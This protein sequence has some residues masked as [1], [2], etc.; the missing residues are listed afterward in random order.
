[1]AWISSDWKFFDQ[2]IPTAEKWRAFGE[3]GSRALYVDI[4]TDGGMDED[5]ITVLGCYDGRTA[6]TF[7]RGRDLESTV[8]DAQR[9]IEEQVKL[10]EGF[11]TEWHGEYDQLQD[12]KQRL[13]KIVPVTLLLIFLLVYF[14]LHSLRDAV[15]VLIA[16]PFSLR[17]AGIAVEQHWKIYLPVMLASFVLML[18]AVMGAHA[19]AKLKGWF[20]AAVA[21]LLLVQVLMP[22]L[23]GGVWSITLFLLLFFKLVHIYKRIRY[24][25]LSI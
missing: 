22:W 24:R 16:V 2:R 3:L 5:C 4:E 17:N 11:R 7:V 14:V 19:P 20:T 18:P 25:I 6:H 10:P 9:R 12:E 21:M 23:I 8:M 13:A 15:L 1:M